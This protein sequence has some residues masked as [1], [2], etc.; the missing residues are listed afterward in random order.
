MYLRGKK[1]ICFL[2]GKNITILKPDNKNNEDNSNEDIKKYIYPNELGVYATVDGQLVSECS[3]FDKDS[4]FYSEESKDTITFNESEQRYYLNKKVHSGIIR[5]FNSGIRPSLYVEGEFYAIGDKNIGDI[6]S[7]GSTSNIN[8]LSSLVINIDNTV[9]INYGNSNDTTNTSKE[10]PFG[11]ATYYAFPGVIATL[12]NPYNMTDSEIIDFFN[13]KRIRWLIKNEISIPLLKQGESI[14]V[15]GI[16]LNKT[17][18]GIEL[19]KSKQI[20]S[21]ITPPLANNKN[22]IWSSSDEN[23]ATVINGV[24]TAKKTGSAVITATT[25]EGGFHESTNIIVSE[26]YK[27]PQL[28]EGAYIQIYYYNSKID[29]N[30]DLVIPFYISDENQLEHNEDD[31]SRT[32]TLIVTIDSIERRFTGLSAGDQEI[33]LGKL[34]EGE[35]SIVFQGIDETNNA[36]GMSIYK[37]VLVVNPEDY[38]ITEAQTYSMNDSDL[39]TFNINNKDNDDIDVC[40]ATRDGLNNLW[41]WCV[42]QGYKKIKMLPGTY[43]FETPASSAGRNIRLEIPSNFTIDGVAKELVKF[44]RKPLLEEC[45]L[46][47]TSFGWE[48]VVDSHLVNCTIEDDSQERIDAN[49]DGYSYSK[50]N[51]EGFTTFY[52]TGGRYSSIE[53]CKITNAVGHSIVNVG[54]GIT[55]FTKNNYIFDET[56]LSKLPPLN[57]EENCFILN[58]EKIFNKKYKTTAMSDLKNWK[59]RFIIFGNPSGYSWMKGLSNYVYYHFYDEDGDFV[60]TICTQ[61][62]RPIMIPYGCRYVRASIK[63]YRTIEEEGLTFFWKEQGTNLEF[64]NNTFQDCRTTCFA[65]TCSRGILIEGNTYESC[66]RKIT[67]SSVDFEDGWQQCIDIYY[68]KNELIGEQLGSCTVIAVDGVNHVYE[69]NINHTIYA[70]SGNGFVIRNCNNDKIVSLG[71]KYDHL[72]KYNRVYDNKN[73]KF[74]VWGM[75]G[76]LSSIALLYNERNAYFRVNGGDY[77]NFCGGYR[78]YATDANYKPTMIRNSKIEGGGSDTYCYKCD[79]FA[80]VNPRLSTTS[81]YLG[82]K[83]YFDNCTFYNFNDINSEVKFSF[84]KVDSDR[85]FK[86]CVFKSPTMLWNHNK[87]NTGWWENCIFENTMS[88][89][90]H[91]TE[92]NVEGDI[93][94]DNCIFKKMVIIKPGQNNKVQFNECIFENGYTLEGN[95]GANA[96]FN[97]TMPSKAVKSIRLSTSKFNVGLGGL[98]SKDVQLNIVVTPMNAINKELICTSDNEGVASV[99]K[100]GLVTCKAIGKAIITCKTVDG[101]YE[102]T[103]TFDITK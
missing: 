76:E 39:T 57:T 87:F 1:V 13:G 27:E 93:Q 103:A 40:I 94:F 67:P 5:D 12:G 4:K 92:F 73:C 84:N 82:D 21:K 2:N 34:T 20:I 32:F 77:I 24:V 11:I 89:Y 16:K 71:A 6:V 33:N 66:G 100:Y 52:L 38:H 37:E 43:R 51:G 60:T 63:G 86:N 59:S 56:K 99:T 83:L 85:W 46:G 35:H 102:T 49:L 31:H 9:P 62:Y 48:N 44:K 36:K 98:A 75:N 91:P 26:P 53:N 55:E 90:T 22:I 68:R 7:A 69:D 10:N 65:N 96:V 78:T 25:Q 18:I 58:G 19:N 47:K 28:F 72:H 3:L 64:K 8:K 42:E 101:S 70:K 97:N 74:D 41:R 95:Y 50:P 54:G 23:V 80:N 88:I 81:S 29:T 79:I 61:Q 30:T 17:I 15:R 14:G 45:V